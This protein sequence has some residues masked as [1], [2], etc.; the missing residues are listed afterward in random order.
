MSSYSDRGM[1]TNGSGS[2]RHLWVMLAGCL[3]L[4]AAI[5]A[6]G[7][8]GLPFTAVLTFAVVLLCPLMMLTMMGGH[9]HASAPRGNGSS[10]P[11]DRPSAR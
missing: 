3:A 9:D 7:V 10:V 5:F 4:A 1:T 8:L 2:S 6:V 11:E